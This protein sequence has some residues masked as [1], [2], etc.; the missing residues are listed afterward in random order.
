MW[1]RQIHFFFLKPCMRVRVCVLAR[2]CVRKTKV[3][4]EIASCLDFLKSVYGIFGFNLSM[5]LSTRPEKYLGDLPTWDKAE[6]VRD[7]VPQ[8]AA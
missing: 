8:A 5:A 2:E 7:P 6:Q 4:A 1:T 3:G